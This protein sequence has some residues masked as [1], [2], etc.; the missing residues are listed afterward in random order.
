MPVAQPLGRAPARPP[1]LAPRPSPGAE[2]SFGRV[3]LCVVWPAGLAMTLV[4]AARLA[5]CPVWPQYSRQDGCAAYRAYLKEHI[6]RD[7]VSDNDSF[8]PCTAKPVD[9]HTRST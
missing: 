1:P 4:A 9:H 5:A 8:V 3:E 2:L 6:E 7:V